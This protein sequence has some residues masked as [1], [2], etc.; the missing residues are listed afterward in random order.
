MI[1]NWE[2]FELEITKREQKEKMRKLDNK[3]GRNC[4]E[5]ECLIRHR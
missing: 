5:W 3:Q 2:E 1:T 4:P